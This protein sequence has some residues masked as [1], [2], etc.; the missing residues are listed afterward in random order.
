MKEV[1]DQE[2]LAILHSFQ[3]DKSLSPDGW[4][5]ELDLGFYD[6]NGKDLLMVVEESRREGFIHAPLNSM[7]ISLIPKKD[8]PGKFEDFRPIS[9]CNYLYKIISNIIAKRLKGVLS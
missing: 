9:L 1:F 7:I 8:N 2:L 4:P 6:L 3:K 5:I